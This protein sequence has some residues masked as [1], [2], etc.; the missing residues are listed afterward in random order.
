MLPLSHLGKVAG[1]ALPNS[2]VLPD[3]ASTF[4]RYLVKV[5]DVVLKA[6]NMQ[7]GHRCAC[8]CGSMEAYG[9]ES[10]MSVNDE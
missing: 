10:A 8:I 4:T 2:F 7:S 5:A 1:L 9:S 6:N 3:F